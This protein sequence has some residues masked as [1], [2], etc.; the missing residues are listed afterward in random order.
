MTDYEYFLESVGVIDE[1]SFYEVLHSFPKIYDIKGIDFSDTMYTLESKDEI[2]QCIINSILSDFP[3]VWCKNVNFEEKTFELDDCDS[4][5]DLEN[6]KKLF[7]ESNWKLSNYDEVKQDLIDT[8]INDEDYKK[9]VM[10]RSIVNNIPF[11][12]VKKLVEKYGN[13]E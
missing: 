11:S 1:N 10:L 12:E 13:K 9:T 2:S 7:S 6:I 5:K 8:D 4:L 3:F